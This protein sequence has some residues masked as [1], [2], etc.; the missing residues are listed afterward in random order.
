ML[1]CVTPETALKMIL[2]AKLK[3]F[4]GTRTV[5]LCEAVGRIAA[6]DVL[7]GERVPAYDR[8]CVDGYALKAS[9]TFG[10]SQPLPSMIKCIGEIEMGE[11]AERVLN[12]GMCLKIPTGGRLPKN[13]D[14]VV[15]LEYTETTKDGFCCV[16]KPCAPFENV[17]RAG[18]D[19]KAGQ[20]VLYKNTV[21][22]AKNIGILAAL[23]ICELKVRETFKVGVVSTGDELVPINGKPE[24]SQIRDVNSSLL[25]V[26]MSGPRI[27]VKTY[28][29]VKDSFDLLREAAGNALKENDMLLLSGGSSVGEKDVVHAVLSE[30]GEVVFHG[31]SMKPGKPTMFAVAD[32]KPVF[33]LP[34]HPLAAY[35]SARLFALPLANKMLGITEKEKSVQRKALYNIPSNHGRE[36]ILPVVLQKGGK[37]EFFKPV[38]SKSGVISVLS[39]ADGFI[40]IDGNAEG[41][42]KGEKARVYL[43]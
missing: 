23:G 9:D 13:A 17:V 24:G 26:L 28:P 21:I 1:E 41:V 19:I 11:S 8:S 34:G 31:V 27:E 29:I 40:R 10:C 12:D 14:C 42:Q 6:E 3:P 15:M 20:A 16:E 37:E 25:S 5:E 33:G 36:E 7:S 2:A 39:T 35:F 32:K 22:E 38:F 43:F 18:D 4:R 30:L